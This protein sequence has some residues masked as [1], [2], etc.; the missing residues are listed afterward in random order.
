MI[1]ELYNSLYS[2]L[3]GLAHI[4]AA[5]VILY[6]YSFLLKHMKPLEIKGRKIFLPSPFLIPLAF[7]ILIYAL[8]EVFNKMDELGY[9]LIK[10]GA[11][12]T[13]FIIIPLITISI[14]ITVLDSV[15]RFM[16][17]YK[18]CKSESG[19]NDRKD[20]LI[21]M[22][23][24][25]YPSPPSLRGKEHFLLFLFLAMILLL[26]TQ[27]LLIGN[28]LPMILLVFTIIIFV[29]YRLSKKN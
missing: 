26:S 13:Y 25:Y 24:R 18:F 27:S 28:Y 3:G 14:I 7:I 9:I 21:Y 20:I 6:A 23:A 8:F 2:T 11:A 12:V 10:L 29:F 4:F 1:P 15:T 19:K 5:I 17:Y 22:G 16:D